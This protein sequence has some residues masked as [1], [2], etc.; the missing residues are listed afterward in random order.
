MK[1]DGKAF[2]GSPDTESEAC[3]LSVQF[4]IHELGV[5][6]H[7]YEI[8]DKVSQALVAFLEHWKFGRFNM[9][10]QYLLDEAILFGFAIFG[11]RVKAGRRAKFM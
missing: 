10:V 8:A 7:F 1:D 3:I 4:A 6:P 11:V 5:A 2:V 9:N